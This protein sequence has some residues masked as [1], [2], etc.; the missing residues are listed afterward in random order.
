MTQLREA[1]HILR[2]RSFFV[3]KDGSSS[4]IMS[5]FKIKVFLLYEGLTVSQTHLSSDLSPDAQT[6]D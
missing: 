6:D 1:K 4:D 5:P 3:R 2:L